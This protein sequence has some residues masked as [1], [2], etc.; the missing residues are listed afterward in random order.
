MFWKTLPSLF[1]VGLFVASPLQGENYDPSVEISHEV[2][3]LIQ[4]ASGELVACPDVSMSRLEKTC[5][6]TGVVDLVRIE[7][8]AEREWIVAMVGGEPFYYLSADSN[9]SD[10]GAVMSLLTLSKLNGV[11]V[12]LRFKNWG[13]EFY[14]TEASF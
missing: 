5:L 11:P 2:V 12:T 8:G 13:G 6:V 1:V 9:P 4:S 7:Q 3:D 14:I 10:L